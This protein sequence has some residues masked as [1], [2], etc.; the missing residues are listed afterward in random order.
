MAA[1][2]MMKMSSRVII[3]LTNGGQIID[4]CLD[5]LIMNE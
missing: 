2:V 3:C 1:K 5:M 4:K